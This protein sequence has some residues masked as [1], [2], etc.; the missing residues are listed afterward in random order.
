MRMDCGPR[1]FER[2]AKIPV[3]CAHDGERRLSYRFVR[4]C[5]E[6]HK[7]VRRIV[8]SGIMS[9]R[10]DDSPIAIIDFETT[11]W[12]AGRDRVVE[13]SVARLDPGEEPRLVLD[14]LVNPERSVK[15]TEI[16]GITD[17]DVRD[18]PLFS[19]IAGDVVEALSGCAVAAYNV[20]FDIKFLNYEL[21]RAG[22]D[23]EVPHFCL[24]YMMPMLELGKKCRLEEACTSLGI[25]YEAT[26]VAADDVMASSRLFQEYL[27]ILAERRINTF[28]D[29]SQLK[30]YKFSK[31]FDSEPLPGAR[32]F[33]LTPQFSSPVSRAGF[34]LAVDPIRRA[35]Q[36]YWD[37]LTTV[38]ADLRIS[39]DEFAHIKAIRKQSSL[40]KEQLRAMHA[41][42]F[43]DAIE[44]FI[45][46]DWLDDDELKRL[47]KLHKCLSVL[48]W[49][50]GE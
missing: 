21:R 17:D 47:R 9:R 45:D 39:E 24:M 5:Q 50:P 40:E 12:S 2:L 23:Q 43:S 14:T 38:L 20:Y 41:R 28:S 3:A 44:R 34:I 49:A 31:S 27:K 4:R 1:C 48:G 29:L 16:H 22:V 42:A 18:A 13:V 30:S 15:A 26:H 6:D 10:I 46:D 35:W 37:A 19:D 36:V 8:P 32:T 33:D 7:Q 11:G 25:D